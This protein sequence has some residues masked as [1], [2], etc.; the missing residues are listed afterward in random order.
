MSILWRCV[1][2]KHHL[3]LPSTAALIRTL[4]QNPF[5]AR[6]CGIDSPD[7][8]PHKATF[9]RFFLRL[10]GRWALVKLKDVSRALVNKHYAELPAFGERVALDS[11]AS[12]NSL[13]PPM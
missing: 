9:S 6:A 7:R 13:L 10:S 5:I 11:T 2:T 1:V 3:G 12:R 8:I 4:G